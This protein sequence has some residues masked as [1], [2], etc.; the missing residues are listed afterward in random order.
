MTTIVK[1]LNQI[2][3]FIWNKPQWIISIEEGID[4]IFARF[5]FHNDGVKRLHQQEIDEIEETYC[6]SETELR[7]EYE[8]RIDELNVRIEHLK[9]HIDQLKYELFLKEHP[10]ATLDEKFDKLF[11][12]EEDDLPF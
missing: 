1:I 8:E 3:D 4:N 2:N 10:N 11:G 7:H 5:V 6:D 12:E 9:N